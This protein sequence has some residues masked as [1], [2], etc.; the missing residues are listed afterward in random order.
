MEV[1]SLDGRVEQLDKG[2]CASNMVALNLPEEAAE[3]PSSLAASVGQQLHQAA[4]AFSLSAVVHAQ[5]V[6]KP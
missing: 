5:R 6:G 1:Q 4:S 3:S 2:S